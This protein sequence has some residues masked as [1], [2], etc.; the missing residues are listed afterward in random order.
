MDYLEYNNKIYCYEKNF[1][2]TCL[3][4]GEK[5]SVSN[6]SFHDIEHMN[7]KEVKNLT[8]EEA[9]LKIGV[10]NYTILKNFLLRIYKEFGYVE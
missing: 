1:G 10:K 2:L 7:L 8:S 9:L 4:D 3:F 5:W 6:L